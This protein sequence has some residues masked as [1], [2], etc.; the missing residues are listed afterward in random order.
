M[1]EKAS[2]CTTCS[3]SYSHKR[4]IVFALITLFALI[5]PFIR[6]GGNHLFLLSF[7]K[8]Q[9]HLFFTSFSTQELFLMPFVLIFGFLFIFFITTL[10]GR[11]WCGWSCPQ[12]IMR[13]I[14][15]DLIQTKLLGIRKNIANKQIKPKGKFALEVVAMLIWAVL[16][17]VI[18][19]N[20]IWFFI[21]P[22]DFFNYIQ[23]PS[24]HLF[25]IGLV[26]CF[27][28]FIFLD[29]VFIKENFC[30]YVCPY[31]RVQSVMFDNDTVQVIYDEKR[32]GKIYDEHHVKIGKK[33]LGKDDEC[34]GCEACVHVCPTHIDIRRGMQLECINC[35]ECSDACAKVM[36]KLGKK[37][38][39]NWTSE[40]A[41][42]SGNKIKFARFR[43]VGY[44]VVLLI[45]AI[46]LAF[47]TTK[48]EHMLLNI[49]RDSSLYEIN[50]N[51][52]K[53]M[54]ENSY[55][56]LI[57]NTDNKNHAYYFN[58][59]NPD[60]KIKRPKQEIKVS[61]G[62]KRKLVVTLYTE[63]QLANNDRKD[64][65]LPIVITAYAKDDKEKINVKRDTI[66]VYP[67]STVI[68]QKRMQH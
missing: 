43:T 40:N 34:I 53:M 29:V 14:Y 4:Y 38:L 35:L 52:E 19:S 17:L 15:R 6:I 11:I 44:V 13:T 51:H 2:N 68:E 31:A 48:K 42:E 18:A 63:K 22:E 61:K 56:F 41:I 60:I 58:I 47:M 64:T 65:I 16:S 8:Q 21:P 36:G 54:V 46:A 45:V 57:E 10:G 7:D 26:L 66:F 12:T 3:Q 67:K 37:S 24:E 1:S 33:P 59:D 23:N 28:I 39:I 62:E 9:L 50:L 27:A 30:I 32:G 20:L 5:A 25:L 55:I 49:N